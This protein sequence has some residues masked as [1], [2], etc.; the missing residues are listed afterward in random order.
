MISGSGTISSTLTA[1][2]DSQIDPITRDGGSGP[3]TTL[4][5]YDAIRTTETRI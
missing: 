5:K 3:V 2:L 1:L 4:Y